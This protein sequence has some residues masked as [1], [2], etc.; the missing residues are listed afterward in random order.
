MTDVPVWPGVTEYL[1]QAAS[2]ALVVSDGTWSVPSALSPRCSSFDLTPMAGM[3]TATGGDLRSAGSLAAFAALA[4]FV[5]GVPVVPV[6]P[7]E[8]VAGIPVEPAADAAGTGACCCD[9]S[10]MPTARTPAALSSTPAK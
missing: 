1:Y 6:V 8:L 3:L 9:S 10:A 7:V 5:P 2:P 4:A